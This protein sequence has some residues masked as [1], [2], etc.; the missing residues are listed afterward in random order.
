M[1]QL[2]IHQE[3]HVGGIDGPPPATDVRAVVE[4]QAVGLGRRRCGGCGRGG[5]RSGWR[6]LGCRR[7]QDNTELDGLNLMNVYG[8]RLIPHLDAKLLR[9]AGFHRPRNLAAI[10]QGDDISEEPAA[11]QQAELP[12]DE[13][14]ESSHNHIPDCRVTLNT[15]HAFQAGADRLEDDPEIEFASN[16]S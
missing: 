7:R 8:L 13:Q 11:G 2:I 6:R 5:S 16:T 9:I 15:S 12:E 10:L 4:N 1:L 14:E 3:V